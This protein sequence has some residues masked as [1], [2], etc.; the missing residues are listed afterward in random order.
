[1]IKNNYKDKV[2]FLESLIA[3]MPGHV[4][5][6]DKNGVYL[7]ANDQ[8]ARFAGFSFGKELVGK[9]DFDLPWK[10]EAKHVTDIDQK[11]IKT[12]KLF[13]VTEV[14]T[15]PNEQKAI[16][17]SQKVPLF[18]NNNTVVGILGISFNITAQQQKIK[19]LLINEK[20]EAEKLKKTVS[21]YLNSITANLPCHVYWKDKDGVYLGCNDAQA[22]SVGFESGKQIIGKT[23]FDIFSRNNAL[24]FKKND[25]EVMSTG[26]PKTTEEPVN[27]YDGT[28]LTVLSTKS[29]LKD[30]EGNIVGIL[31]ISVD[32]TERKQMEENLVEAKSHAEAA[33][34]AKTEFL[35]NMR[36]DIR[37]PLTGIAGFAQI[38]KQESAGTKFAE[39]ADNILASSDALLEF[40]NEILE[41]VRVASGEIPLLRMKFDVRKRLAD[42]IALNQ[43]KAKQK[44]LNLQFDYDETIP[45]YL[46]GDPKRMQRIVLEL[47]TN[48]LN[49]TETGSVKLSM[50]LVKKESR[51]LVLK[52][53]VADTGIGIPP[54]QQQEIFARFKRLTPSYH[55]IYKGAGLGLAVIKQFIDDLEGEIYV[56]GEVNKG[57][58]FTCL[59]PFKEALLENDFGLEKVQEPPISFYVTAPDISP[60]PVIGVTT[61]SSAPNASRILLVEDTPIA[62]KA[63]LHI[64]SA[65][66]CQVD[67][68][69]NG[70][71]AL[72]LAQQQRYD[73][74][75]MDVGLPDISGLEVTKRIRLAEWNAETSV[76]IIAL[77]AHG[78]VDNKQHCVEAGMN[79]VLTKPLLI[80]TARDILNAFIPNR[81]KPEIASQ[82]E[83]PSSLLILEGDLF[84]REKGL[85][86]MG[87]NAALLDELI[88]MLIEAI[89][90]DLQ[91]L[92]TAH[93]SQ[94]WKEIQE[95]V[96]RL[97]GGAAYCGVTRLQEACSHLE[98]YLRSHPR[99][100][101]TEALYQQVIR[102]M[103]ALR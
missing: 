37:T 54:N 82:P 95:L 32:I 44:R 34:K 48:A 7:G 65:L 15:L 86:Q 41:A 30:D 77:T 92:E 94:N 10:K 9:T 68:A 73:L 29:P 62:V 81:T 3:A 20:A 55:G 59:L 74:I 93:K 87:G 11:V 47:V 66:D 26:R 57:T 46:L 69:P 22:K 43:A 91:Q 78:D 8:Q 18:D 1:M 100:E 84:D 6:K 40:M 50:Q 23:D 102:E 96:H 38:L 60:L 52:I 31:G 35:E 13:E 56:E 75:F 97:K 27:L 25:E 72:K 51:D 33:N 5:W 49:F 70:E 21:G 45:K 58:T 85:Q 36:H 14:V 19:Q 76:P 101:L 4:Y 67:H 71:T 24:I 2:T 98:S 90:D 12:K 16:F 79:A 99:E 42:V 17:L 63:A 53:V 83:A 39:Y 64:L 28:H 80:D 61:D 103:Q 88:A 89:P